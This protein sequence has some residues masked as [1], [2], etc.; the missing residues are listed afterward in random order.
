MRTCLFR[1]IT[2]EGEAVDVLVIGY[3]VDLD[4]LE[5]LIRPQLRPGAA[6]E[7]ISPLRFIDTYPVAFQVLVREVLSN[8]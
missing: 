1:V 4:N 8:E 7:S 6:I 5:D 3:V 2:A